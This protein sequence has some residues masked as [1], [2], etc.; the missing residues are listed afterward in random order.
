MSKIIVGKY[1]TFCVRASQFYS[2][3][4]KNIRGHVLVQISVVGLNCLI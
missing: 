1:L 3:M 2:S 4:Y